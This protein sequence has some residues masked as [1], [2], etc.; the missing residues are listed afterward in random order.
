MVCNGISTAAYAAQGRWGEAGLSAASMI[1]GSAVGTAIKIG[2][3][4]GKAAWVARAA[5]LSAGRNMGTVTRNY[6]RTTH[7]AAYMGD[8]IASNHFQNRYQRMA[9]KIRAKKRLSW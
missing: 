4:V 9:K 7:F 3:R 1:T 6:H 5:R 8:Q 2:A